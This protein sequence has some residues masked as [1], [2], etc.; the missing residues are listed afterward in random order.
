MGI[1]ENVYI[2]RK[3]LEL[4]EDVACS[5]WDCSEKES[6]VLMSIAEIHG[7]IKLANALKE[8]DNKDAD[9]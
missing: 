9:L 1:S 5:V 2:D 8:G 7:I 4:I 6:W 3:A